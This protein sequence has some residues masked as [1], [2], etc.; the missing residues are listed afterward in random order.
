MVLEFLVVLFGSAYYSG[1]YISE[2]ADTCR[3][4]KYRKLSQKI[5]ATRNPGET[6]NKYQKHKYAAS[7]EVEDE[8]NELLGD[9][10]LW[11][12]TQSGAM[13]ASCGIDNPDPEW[14]VSGIAY[15]LWL[16]KRGYVPGHG[17]VIVS[18]NLFGKIAFP[19][20]EAEWKYQHLSGEE[21]G[22]EILLKMFQMIENNIQERYGTTSDFQLY[23]VEH[24]DYHLKSIGVPWSLQWGYYFNKCKA[25][26]DR[27]V[28]RPW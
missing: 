20:K 27:I 17:H 25:F 10:W 16:S 2:K 21:K 8:L 23:L 3:A 15:N 7:R 1:K 6:E 11:L 18:P 13:Y 22:H 19:T 5:E 12:L 28:G 14:S 24:G 26:G 9:D 4:E